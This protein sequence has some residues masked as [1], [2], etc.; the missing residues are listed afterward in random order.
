MCVRKSAASLVIRSS[1]VPS[2][3]R[4]CRLT[5]RVPRP[6]LRFVDVR[7][8]LAGL[9]PGLHLILRRAFRL[10]LPGMKGAVLGQF[11]VGQS[12]RAVL[13]GVGERIGAVVSD[14]QAAL[15]LNQDEDGLGA[16]VLD[17]AGFDVA[18]DADPRAVSLIT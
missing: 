9:H 7:Q 16:E 3:K 5:Q 17:G 2:K 4:A 8:R 11:A 12:L 1:I 13:E 15:V 18:A 10:N 14:G 6:A